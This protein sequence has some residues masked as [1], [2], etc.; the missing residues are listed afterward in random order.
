M[1]GTRNTGIASR[2]DTDGRR[3]LIAQQ[4]GCS[5]S[6]CEQVFDY[7]STPFDPARLGPPPVL[8][9]TS[10]AHVNDWRRYA[11][12][13]GD[14]VFPYLQRCFPQLAIPIRDGISK[15]DLYARAVRRGEAVDPAAFGE[16]LQLQNPAGLRLEI[17]EHP[18]GALPVL[19]VQDRD[20][21]ATL[22][23]A[24]ACRN[25]PTPIGPAVNA[26]MIA[27]IVNWDRVRRYRASWSGGMAPDDTERTWPAEMARVAATAPETFRDRIMLVATA[28]Y[29]S[30]DAHD[31]GLPYEARRWRELSHVI[32]VE[33][34]FTHY[35]T[36]RLYGH[37]R[38]NLFDELLADFM[39]VTAALGTFQARWFLTF[40]GLDPWP[41]VRPDGR[42]H[43]YRADLSE[44]AFRVVCEVTRRAAEELERLTG[45]RY[46]VSERSRFFLALSWMTL[47][48]LAGPDCDALF[49]AAYLRAA[50]FVS[51]LARSDLSA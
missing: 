26:Q 1:S 18:A 44:E 49:A 28:S 14:A 5:K 25:E 22:V 35:T 41:D 8:P 6:A 20:D 4:F 34:E 17:H 43:T 46:S 23:R 33:H 11:A 48:L 45:A 32:R 9:L 12:E 15:S 13:A 37:M 47:D 30:V 38:N 2:D 29:S 3:E 51:T 10:D 19:I 42:V 21:F 50:D 24:L 36:K 40:I 7:C 16:A 39:G 27:G 31:L